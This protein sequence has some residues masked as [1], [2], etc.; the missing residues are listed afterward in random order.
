[1]LDARPLPYEPV[2][3]GETELWDDTAHGRNLTTSD[4]E[5]KTA[6]S[7]ESNRGDGGTARGLG[8]AGLRERECRGLVKKLRRL[9]VVPPSRAYEAGQDLFLKGEPGD[10]LYVLTKGMARLYGSYS[11]GKEMALRLVGPWEPFGDLA[12]GAPTVQGASAGAF[13]DCEVI[14]VPKVFVVRAIK[15]DREVAVALLTLYGMEIAYGKE[16]LGCLLPRATGARLGV[17]LPLLAERFGEAG[18][19]GGV[20]L[21]PLT[22]SDL[23]AMIAATRESVTTAIRALR[24]QGVLKKEG[25]TLT[26][27]K[28]EKLALAARRRARVA[29]PS[30]APGSGLGRPHGAGSAP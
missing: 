7:A 28:P 26:I 20:S 30:S 11:D 24:R 16:L 17:L 21:P 1:M 29:D 12:P 13:T 25:Q 14:K 8:L 5:L 19:E 2:A 10:G 6:F 9:E 3:S 27:L 4:A 15:T 22:H 23:A 18:P